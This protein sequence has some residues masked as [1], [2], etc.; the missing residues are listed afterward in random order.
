MAAKTKRPSKKDKFNTIHSY[1][2][3]EFAERSGVSLEAMRIKAE[4]VKN[5][6]SHC[7]RL[8][9]SQRRL[10]S[11]V[12]GLQQERVSNI[13]RMEGAGTS[14]DKLVAIAHALKLKVE[15]KMSEAA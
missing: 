10:A 7:E 11:M 13:Y 1:S 5:I 4:M 2:I 9:I 12:P 8:G 14:I 6:R 3:E 15:L